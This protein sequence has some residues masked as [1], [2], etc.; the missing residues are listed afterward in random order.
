V[1]QEMTATNVR[2]DLI[3]SETLRDVRGLLTKLLLCLLGF[4]PSK[5][6]H[7]KSGQMYWAVKLQ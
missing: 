7:E 4:H 1:L 6:Y 3:T 2:P 5:I